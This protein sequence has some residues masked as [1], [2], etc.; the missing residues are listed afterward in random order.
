MPQ[1]LLQVA[2]ASHENI[3]HNVRTPMLTFGSSTRPHRS[4][5]AAKLAAA[6][7][8]VAW[9]REHNLLAAPG[10]PRPRRKHYAI[11]GASAAAANMSTAAPAPASAVAL[12]PAPA[13]P[14]TT[15]YGHRAALLRDKLGLSNLAYR[16]TSDAPDS[17][18][19]SGAAHF[20]DEADP[21]LKGPLC[22]V[23]HVHGKHSAKEEIARRVC[24]LLEELLRERMSQAAE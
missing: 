14:P 7:E 11:L 4:K 5:K 12:A 13:P 18:Y 3:D 2:S 19:V 15:S 22:P 1:S 20:L 23:R 21:R 9:L 8:A 17:A 24:E 10:S 16:L 6:E